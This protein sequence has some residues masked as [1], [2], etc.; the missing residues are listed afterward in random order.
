M[1]YLLD[2]KIK[3]KK[4]SYIILGI[5]VFILLFYF[6]VS[7]F[8]GL[9]YISHAIFR[10][11]LILG[12]N[13]GQKFSNIGQFLKNKK[14][15]LLENESL[16]SQILAS[17]ADRANYASILDEND[18]L[19]EVL[20]R[21][22]QNQNMLLAAILSKPNRS[23]YDTLIIDVGINQGAAINQKVFALGNMPIGKI[24]ETYANSSKVVLYSSPGEKTEVIITGR[25][26]FMQ[27]IGRGGG[28][29]EMILPKDFNLDNGTEV[30][31][32]GITPR[33]L[34]TVI[35][36]IS[37]PRDAFVKAL[38]VSPVNIQELKFVEVEK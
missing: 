5:I 17:Q 8:N 32:P 30:V 14:S 31:L 36:I 19:K 34:G 38:L 7:I 27:V 15:I 9:S 21:K 35:K 2:K 24:S 10:P 11:V 4:L 20:G 13:L 37:D 33:I 3:R 16:K 25:D 12:N 29:F 26:I 6:R 1:S 23:V 18:K 28:N 22:K